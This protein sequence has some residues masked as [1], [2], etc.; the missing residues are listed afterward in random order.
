MSE[1]PQEHK[2]RILEKSAREGFLTM[3][4]FSVV[5]DRT[6]ATVLSMKNRGD[7]TAIKVG[8]AYRILQS[9]V[10]RFVTVGNK[11]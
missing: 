6:Y 4:E 11:E 10:H 5:I 9:E 7:I 3:R 2:R 1:V 8:G